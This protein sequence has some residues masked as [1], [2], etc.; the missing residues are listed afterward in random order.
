MSWI[1]S[2]WRGIRTWAVRLEEFF[3]CLLLAVMILLSCTQIVMR[4]FFSSGLPWAEPL[5]RHMVLWAGLLGAAVATRQNKHIVIDIASHFLPG[6]LHS[7]LALIV[8]LFAAT[9]TSLLAY[10]AVIFVVNEAAYSQGSA[11]PGIPFWTLGLIFPFCFTIMAYRFI[12]LA[13][14][15]TRQALTGKEP[16]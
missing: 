1:G 12:V 10:A 13:I 3:L 5:L 8:N 4:V 16:A 9:V 6:F 7:W 2:I 14:A 15:T 11:I